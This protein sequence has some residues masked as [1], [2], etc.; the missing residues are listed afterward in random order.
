MDHRLLAEPVYCVVVLLEVDDAP[1]SQ[2]CELR[3]SL[4]PQTGSLQ[5]YRNGVVAMYYVTR[6]C[7]RTLR[8]TKT[9]RQGAP[10]TSQRRKMVCYQNA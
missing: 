5:V 9:C 7:V 10:Q 4:L 3:S 6:A 8:R 2:R 1:E